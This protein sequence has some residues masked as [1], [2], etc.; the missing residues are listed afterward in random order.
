MGV[1]TGTATALKEWAVCERALAAGQTILLLRKGG[2]REPAKE[3]RVEHDAFALYPTYE[4]QRGDLLKPA[5]GPLLDATLA[6]APAP[7]TLHVRLWLAVTDG[8]E[9]TD[10]EHLAALSP[11]HIWT[12][13]YAE[14]RLRWK[15]RKPLHALLVR[16][17]RLASELMLPYEARYG[18]C[19]SWVELAA[20]PDLAGR[21]PVL[22]DAAYADMAAPIR[23]VL[24]GLPNMKRET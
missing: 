13:G 21:T 10:A 20:V 17:Y 23:A 15:P 6:E 24:A 3:F 4:H 19:T 1:M 14:E 22:D 9:L 2:I 18:G 7:G 5:F 8:Y 12:D 16:A 11:Y